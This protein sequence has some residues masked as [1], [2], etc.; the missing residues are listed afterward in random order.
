MKLD[1]SQFNAAAAY[2]SVDLIEDRVRRFVP[3]VRKA[4]WHIHGSAM[5]E[6]DVEDLIQVGLIALTECAQRHAGP[7]EDG[8]AAYAKIRVRGAIL[9]HVRRTIPG[10][11]GS[12]ARRRRVE[13]ATSRLR[14]R[15]RREPR[16]DELAAE[17]VEIGGSLSDLE[18]EPMRTASLDTMYDD[19]SDMFADD[20]PNPFE[21]LSEHQDSERLGRI[22]AALPERLQTVLQ[23]YFVEE[24]NLAEIAQVLEVSVPRVHQ[25]K[26]QALKIVR[27]ELQPE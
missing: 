22:V 7:T 26:A 1:Q 8:F 18:A 20:R 2:G 10:S 16:A 5:N 13:H 21:L 23:L 19:T 24:L 3:M 14:A 27:K 17:I 9:D 6:F 15:L 4:A 12:G 25:L 11:R